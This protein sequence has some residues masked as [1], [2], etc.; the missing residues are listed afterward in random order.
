MNDVADSDAFDAP[1]RDANKQRAVVADVT[2]EGYKELSRA[3]VIDP[4]NTAFNRDVVW[5]A[6]AFAGK[7][8]YVRNDKECVC[9]DLAAGTA[10]S[11]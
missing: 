2:K 11:E 7:R 6:P 9:V 8:F 1:A 3:H 10:T 4:S 5:C